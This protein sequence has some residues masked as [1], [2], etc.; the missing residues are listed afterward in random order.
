MDSSRQ[1]QLLPARA[2]PVF[3]PSAVA[4]SSSLAGLEANGDI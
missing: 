4:V 3:A 2:A 1:L